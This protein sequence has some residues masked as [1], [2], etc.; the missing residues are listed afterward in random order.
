MGEAIM[1]PYLEL[2]LLHANAF[3]EVKALVKDISSNINDVVV[4]TSFPWVRW[5]P[6]DA[7]KIGINITVE[8]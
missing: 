6:N 2:V 5:V 1:L 4:E 8:E 7:N 3:G